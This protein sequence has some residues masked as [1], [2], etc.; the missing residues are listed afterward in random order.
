MRYMG[1]SDLPPCAQEEDSDSLY[2][3]FVPQDLDSLTEK[4]FTVLQGL[5]GTNTSS[6]RVKT[7]VDYEDDD[8]DD[9]D[10]DDEPIVP[11]RISM[12]DD[13]DDDDDDSD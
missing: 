7:E 11:P 10:D 12:N 2:T 1:A 8:E 13:D 6:H 5:G 9:D 3:G 4:Q